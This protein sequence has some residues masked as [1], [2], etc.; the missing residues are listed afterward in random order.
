MDTIEHNC[1]NQQSWGILVDNILFGS[2][3]LMAALHNNTHSDQING[4]ILLG[5]SDDLYSD[6]FDN[7]FQIKT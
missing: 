5:E 1:G 6:L 4:I 3:W 2:Q 7:S